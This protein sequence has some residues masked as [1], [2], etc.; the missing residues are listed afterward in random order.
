MA[1]D[2]VPA[3]HG[4]Q[5]EAGVHQLSIACPATPSS[6]RPVASGSS[7]AIAP[8][9]QRG[10]ATA[11]CDPARAG[12]LRIGVRVGLEHVAVGRRAA[13][14]PALADRPSIPARLFS[15]RAAHLPLGDL[16]GGRCRQCDWED[17]DYEGAPEEPLSVGELEAR[18]AEPCTPSSDI[19]TLI[20]VD[21]SL[22]GDSS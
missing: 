17:P 15:S 9:I 6:T 11:S 5:L 14:V 1:D 8:T 13:G 7:G 18:L 3:G 21:D 22:C 4:R 19:S 20:T 12:L 10:A 2:L 16:A